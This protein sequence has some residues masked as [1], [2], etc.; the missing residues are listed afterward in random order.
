MEQLSDSFTDAA[1]V[2]RSHVPAKNTPLRIQLL[3]TEATYAAPKAKRG[4][5][6]GAMDKQPRQRRSK[7][8]AQSS[9]PPPIS[10]LID[11]KEI[12][13]NYNITGNI[14]NRTHIQ[15]TNLFAFFIAQEITNDLL[16]PITITQ[17]QKQF[18]W[19]K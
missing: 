15:I 6:L 5:P 9:E 12:A 2:T 10:P 14:W 16:D 4:R 18:D 11:N 3:D 17:A 8:T 13:I 19:P 1:K 7:P